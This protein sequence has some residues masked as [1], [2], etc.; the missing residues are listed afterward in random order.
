MLL[1]S[2][3][4][5]SLGELAHSGLWEMQPKRVVALARLRYTTLF[6]RPISELQKREM[7]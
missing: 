3:Y 1:Q 5:E 4:L 7:S 6:P 2:P